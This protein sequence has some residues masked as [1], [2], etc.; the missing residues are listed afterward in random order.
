VSVRFSNGTG[1]VD[2]PDPKPT[3][4]G[5]AVKFHLGPVKAD[6]GGVLRPD[7]PTA[8]PPETD[9]VSMTLPTFFV[10][11]IGVFPDF[12]TAATPRPPTV[13]T[14]WQRFVE[15]VALYTPYPKES[16]D[17]GVY[18]FTV[19]HSE[20]LP[21]AV[22]MSAKFVPESYTT[23]SYH[24]VHA[25]A[26]TGND[27]ITRAARFH[28]EPVDGV[29][30]DRSVTADHYLRDRLQDRITNGQA[31]F[32]LRIQL[33]EEGDD[34]TDPTRPWPSRR[35][36][37]VMGQLRLTNIPTDK[38]GGCE[39]L[40]FNPCLLVDG[41]DQCGDPILAARKNVYNRSYDRRVGADVVGAG[42]VT[43]P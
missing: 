32:V 7:P 1:D 38:E 14:R 31:E 12:V 22:W 16:L 23:C 43:K 25:F 37:I 9:L 26:L 42:P 21:A 13:R 2:E 10:K 20:A 11:D 33:A 39:L 36:R 27:G 6:S 29:R 34:I 28:W 35:P 3:V 24:A 19:H 15:R 5:M 30:S 40:H 8:H 17:Q 18:D 41:I 4:R